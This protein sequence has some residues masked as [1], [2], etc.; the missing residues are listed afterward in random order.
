MNQ[1]RRQPG[2]IY[3]LYE[4]C[5][6]DDPDERILFP[7]IAKTLDVIVEQ[8]DI[9]GV[10]ANRGS[11]A[12]IVRF[13][14]CVSEGF[15]DFSD[16]RSNTEGFY[17]GDDSDQASRTSSTRRSALRGS[18]K[19][20]LEGQQQRRLSRSSSVASEYIPGTDDQGPDTG[21]DTAG[22]SDHGETASSA[23]SSH[24]PSTQGSTSAA[25]EQRDWRSLYTPG[26]GKPTPSLLRGF[27]MSTITATQIEGLFFKTKWSG[28][29]SSSTTRFKDMLKH[30]STV[31]LSENESIAMWTSFSD[32]R[33]GHLLPRSF[34]LPACLTT[35]YSTIEI[36]VR[37]MMLLEEH[38]ARNSALQTPLDRLLKLGG[39][40]LACARERYGRIKVP[41][42]ASPG[43]TYKC[44]FHRDPNSP[45]FVVCN[46]L[47]APALETPDTAVVAVCAGNTKN[48]WTFQGLLRS[49]VVLQGDALDMT[50]SGSGIVTL[51]QHGEQYTVSFPTWRIS[52]LAFGVLS[53]GV[54]GQARIAC[55]QSKL[56]M[57]LNFTAHRARG[58]SRVAGSVTSEGEV[59]GNINGLWDAPVKFTP[60]GQGSA[61]QLRSSV[62][63]L[64][65]RRDVSIRH[66]ERLSRNPTLRKVVLESARHAMA[67][68]ARLTALPALS[69][70]TDSS[71]KGHA[72]LRFGINADNVCF[73][74]TAP[75][76][77]DHSKHLFVL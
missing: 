16:A 18:R 43:E 20:Q 42:K 12:T 55:A 72:K 58:T 61:G 9:P 74:D 31:A 38:L 22:S 13:E 32:I 17:T 29:S 77:A 67:D 56:V 28:F 8:Q 47:A 2:D 51:E 36:H 63:S 14:S 7:L 73:V 76:T 53:A 37:H 75:P 3:S 64:S 60:V 27:R 33:A 11:A 23:P 25:G 5:C 48:S 71:T 4:D 34:K 45:C 59:I 10:P 44:K 52:G 46:H 30:A 39:F 1:A 69:T 62:L 57:E 26:T 6:M 40:M 54:T 41:A 35:S 68:A 49:G 70:P 50:N 66:K 15:S 24:M 19:S 21:M 65:G